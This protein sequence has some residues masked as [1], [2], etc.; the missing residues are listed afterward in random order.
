MPKHVEDAK[1]RSTQ[2]MLKSLAEATASEGSRVG[3]DVEDVR[4]INI[5]NEVFIDRNF[6]ETERTYCKKAPSPQAS[7]AGRWSAKEAVFK[8]LG[9]SSKGAG[10]ALSEIEIVNDEKGAPIVLVSVV[11]LQ[12]IEA[13][14]ANE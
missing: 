10:A 11:M 1:S 9:V 13:T 12:Q 8:C 14:E 7:F 4:A 6:T 2:E 3:V 5:D